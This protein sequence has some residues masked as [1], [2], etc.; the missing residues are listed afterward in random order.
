MRKHKNKEASDSLSQSPQSPFQHPSTYMRAGGK[1]LIQGDD[2]HSNRLKYIDLI[3]SR[4][5]WLIISIAILLA[6]GV[7]NKIIPW[8][9]VIRILGIIPPWAE[10]KH[11]S[12]KEKY[13]DVNLSIATQT[14]IE[15]Q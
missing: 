4:L 5:P 1:C 7:V 3:T 10:R 11:K 15:T 14:A 2:K 8:L 12:T 6:G 13:F 9:T